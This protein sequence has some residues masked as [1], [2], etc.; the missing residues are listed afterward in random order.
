M[1]PIEIEKVVFTE[2]QC[3]EYIGCSPS[4]LRKGRMNG[5]REKGPTPPFVRYGRSIRYLKRDL[6]T[7]LEQHRVTGE[8]SQK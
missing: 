8:G 1:K 6:D 4:W 3:A 2:V 5:Q 7:F